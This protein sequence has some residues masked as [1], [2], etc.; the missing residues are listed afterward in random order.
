[1]TVQPDKRLQQIE[2]AEAHWPIWNATPTTIGL[3]ALQV[4]AIKTATMNARTAYNAAVSAG[5]ASKAAT[6]GYHGTT[7]GMSTLVGEAIK[8]IRL[9]AQ[10]TNNPTVYQT[11]QIP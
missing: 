4:T 8:N 7:D 9:Y 11:A 2:F 10:S 1:M 3:T 5:E 6:Q